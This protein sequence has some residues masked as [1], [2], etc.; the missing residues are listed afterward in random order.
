MYPSSRH[1]AVDPNLENRRI[2]LAELPL[3]YHRIGL[4]NFQC[5][6]FRDETATRRSTILSPAPVARYIMGFHFPAGTVAGSSIFRFYVCPHYDVIWL[7]LF[8]AEAKTVDSFLTRQSFHIF[9][10]NIS[11][12]FSF[13]FLALQGEQ[14]YPYFARI[15]QLSLLLSQYAVAKI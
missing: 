13:I 11:F 1:I 4:Q 3:L 10:D 8:K 15:W 14:K 2:R 5:R 12:T 9:F 7:R 6:R